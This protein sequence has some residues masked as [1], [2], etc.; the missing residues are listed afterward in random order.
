MSKEQAASV[1]VLDTIYGATDCNCARLKPL[2]LLCDKHKPSAHADWL[3]FTYISMISST[4][5]NVRI[6]VYAKRTQD[7]KQTSTTNG[8]LV[9]LFVFLPFL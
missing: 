6:C 1:L 8:M 4:N 3:T 9:L 7:K 2:N 5:Y